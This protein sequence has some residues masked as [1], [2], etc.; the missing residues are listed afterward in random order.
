MIELRSYQQ[1]QINFISKRLGKV[2][3]SIESPTGSGK[4]FVALSVAKKILDEDPRAL[5]VMATG[6]N[7]L[8]EQMLSDAKRIGIKSARSLMG[9]ASVICPIKSEKIGQNIDTAFSQPEFIQ[10]DVRNPGGLCS[11]CPIKGKV[12]CPFTRAMRA[13][14]DPGLLITNHSMLLLL[15]ERFSKASLIIIDEAHMFMSFYD[16]YLSTE[17]SAKEIS[18]IQK[19]LGDSSPE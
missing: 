3:I 11:E 18:Q 12:S 15:Q 2:P 9:R 10:R 8:V 6:I 13:A 19:V 14:S 17:I 1:N 7:V 16:S 5:V 4:S